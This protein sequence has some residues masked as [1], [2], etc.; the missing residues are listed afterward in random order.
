[1]NLKQLEYFATIVEQGTISAAAQK[2]G[3]S[4]PPLSLQLK[5]LEEELGLELVER[6]P[7]GLRMTPAGDLLYQRAQ[8]LLAQAEE[9]R[10]DMEALRK[11]RQSRLRLGMISSCGVVF[12]NDALRR[13]CAAHPGLRFHIMEGNTYGLLEALHE[14]KI[15]LAVVRTP[16][17]MEAVDGFY[18]ERD[19][20]SAVRRGEKRTEQRQQK[21]QAQRP[22]GKPEA[23]ASEERAEGVASEAERPQAPGVSMEELGTETLVTYRRMERLVRDAFRAHGL[24]P[25]LGC[26]ADDARTALMWAAAGMGTAIVPASIVR[27]FPQERIEVR[28][29]REESLHTRTAVVYRRGAVLGSMEKEFLHLFDGKE[30]LR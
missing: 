22:E 23:A 24:D 3:I 19:V 10:M 11:G 6:S 27:A 25:E 16:F 17:S 15:D 18:L 14:G 5:N 8:L 21:R 30:A 20:M 1:M 7:K 4:Q 13:F 2:L 12:L 26:L 28:E 9:T 29:I